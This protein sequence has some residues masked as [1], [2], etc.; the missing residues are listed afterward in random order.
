[1]SRNNNLKIGDD[2][3]V[4]LFMSVVAFALLPIFFLHFLLCFYSAQ[5]FSYFAF[6]SP[7]PLW[8]GE[9]SKNLCALQLLATGSLPQ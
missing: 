2:L 9:M 4:S 5:E 1:M 6:S 3:F 8:V 7:A